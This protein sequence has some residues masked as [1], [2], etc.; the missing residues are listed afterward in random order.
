MS[1]NIMKNGLCII[2]CDLW[3]GLTEWL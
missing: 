2:F 3:T 1:L